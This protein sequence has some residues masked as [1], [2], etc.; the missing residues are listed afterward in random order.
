MT[1]RT[2][3]IH[4]FC[5]WL[6]SSSLLLLLRYLLDKD[7]HRCWWNRCS[8]KI[9]KESNKNNYRDEA[10][11]VLF[12]YGR[13]LFPSWWLASSEV[14]VNILLPSAHTETNK[15]WTRWEATCDNVSLACLSASVLWRHLVISCRVILQKPLQCLLAKVH[16]IIPRTRQ[17]P[18]RRLCFVRFQCRRLSHRSQS[19]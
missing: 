3:W 18:W 5:L 19:T 15:R 16:R 1:R 17:S 9:K 11:I 12:I 2:A 10:I 7:T 8:Q 13:M 14:L 6:T 4:Y